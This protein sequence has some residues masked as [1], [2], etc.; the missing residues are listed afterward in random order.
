MARSVVLKGGPRCEACR[1]PPRWC[2]CSG[3]GTL[4]CPL[5]V[6]VVQHFQEVHKPSST[7]SLLLR[8]LPAA[9]HHIYRHDAPL[10]QDA[11][12]RDGHQLWIIHPAGDPLETPVAG[13]PPVQAVLLDASWSQARGMMR[14]C[15]RWGRR[16]ALP[17]AG[18]S[19]YWLRTQNGEGRFS[20]F[21]AFLFLLEALG[22]RDVAAQHRAQFE[23]HV[24]AGLR[25]RGRIADAARY[26]ESSPIRERY[27]VLLEQLR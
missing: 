12:Q 2:I 22:Y 7:G 15:E 1:Q 23:L 14:D 17:M 26:L 21:E 3:L 13:D 25:A 19:R 10:S 18:E 8:T 11:V 6:D 16:V 5:A 4:P 9:R 20:T 27:P 24:Y